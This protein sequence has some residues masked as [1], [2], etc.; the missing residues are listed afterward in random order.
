M[1][2]EEDLISRLIGE[3]RESGSANGDCA[4]GKQ[5]LAMVYSPV[6]EWQCLYEPGMALQH[7]TLFRELDKPFLG[8]GGMTHG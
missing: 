2:L 3:Q 5:A 7:G 1:Y 4:P 8:A 6:Q